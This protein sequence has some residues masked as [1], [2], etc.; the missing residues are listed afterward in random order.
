MSNLPNLTSSLFFPGFQHLNIMAGGVH[1][2]GVL[3]GDGP[4]LLLLHGFPQTHIAWRKMAPALAKTHTVIIPDLPGYGA[5]QTLDSSTRWNKRRVAAAL[6]AMM[7]KLGH[8]RFALVGHDRG[9]RAGYRLALD[10]L[11]RVS[12]YA[13]LTVVP[14]LDAM[15][16]I[17]FRSAANAF[18]WFLLAQE[19][20]LPERMLASDPDLFLERAFARMTGGR[21]FI[22]PSALEAYRNA[23]RE[24]SVRH[25]MC[26]DYRAALHEDLAFDEVDRAAGH[27]MPCPVLVLWPAADSMAERP[28]PVD[29][30]EQWA[31]TVSGVATSGGHLQPEDAPN[32]V[33]ESLVPFL[34]LHQH[35]VHEEKTWL[36]DQS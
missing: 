12:A 28:T 1:F 10:Y 36:P 24:P 7:D 30:W 4:P 14:T 25:A 15:Q 8:D 32:E 20:D 11:E 29:I 31:S 13:S 19:A 33:L 22:E 2:N 21:D 6:V 17:D 26:E 18:H 35:R 9:A 5:S 27:K 3:G 16:A 34:A 23:F